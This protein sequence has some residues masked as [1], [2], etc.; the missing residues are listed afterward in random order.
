MKEFSPFRLDTVNQCL[1]RRVAPEDEQRVT[2]TPKAFA[3][4]RYLVDHAGRLV[5]QN[6][7]IEAVWPDTYVQPEVLK[8]QIADIRGTLGDHPRNPL[9]IETLPRRGYQFIAEVREWETAEP[10]AP[11]TRHR[12]RLVGR[13]GELG[14]LRDCLRKVMSGQRQL[15]FITG[16]PG[17]GKTALVDGF[18]DQTVAAEPS[19][20]IALGQCV[21]GHGGME[22]YYPMLEAL[23]Q[24]CR[25]PA[26]NRVVDI[27]ATHAPTWLVQFPALLKPEHRQVLRQ[28]IL[29]ATRDR[30][31]REI[32]EALD[33]ISAEAPLLL[34]FEDLQWVDLSTVDLISVLARQRTAAKTM[35]VC[36]KRPVAPEHPLKALKRDLLLHDL[37]KEITLE[38][39]GE[40]DV[41]EYL[42]TESPGVSL[43]DGFPQLIHRHSEGNPLLM[44]AVLDHMTGRGVISRENGA[45]RLSVPVEE[46]AV[47]VPE[48]LRQAI[49]AQIARLTDEQQR[50]LEVASVNGV[51]FSA[52]V[53]AIPANLDEEK[54]ENLCDELSRRHH[55]VR[56]A[57]SREFPDGTLSERYEF[58]HALYREVFYWRQTPGRRAKL[59]QRVGERLEALF[60]GHEHDVAA[61]L[62]H[63]FEKASDW[64]R[65]VRYL[66]LASDTAGQRFQPLRAV[67]ILEHALE[68]ASKLPYSERTTSE[69]P[70][71]E[72][73]AA[74]YAVLGESMRSIET[75]GALAYRAARN[76][77]IDLQVRSLIDMAWPLS[78]ISSQRSLE[79]LDQALQLSARQEDPL[80]RARM[81][82]RCFA[83]P[84]VARL[85]SSGCGGVP[86]CGR[87]DSHLR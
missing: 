22:A 28:E 61:E 3:V 17:I 32:R 74:I 46:I 8:Y 58:L 83:W 51:L 50:A 21:D 18:Q 30:M 65:A 25:S 53:N 87:G 62:A 13:D 26:G 31:L 11:P 43:P 66:L 79:V 6:E 38:P 76:G 84:L 4:L 82:A 63:H 72:K 48:T 67:E 47:E 12:G 27:L 24:L 49:E 33:I 34:V 41:A 52:G 2:L 73:L 39:L 85:E 35:L 64:S 29:G 20:R 59:H 78:W 40:A 75:Y 71:L 54:F 16:E 69:V 60:A 56:W 68:L 15:V 37:C 36:T 1:W 44:L 14:T 57:G 7:L 80:L 42:G 10:G 86:Q 23:G 5:T 9:F 77:L 55:V 45:W 70:I 81:R 19:V